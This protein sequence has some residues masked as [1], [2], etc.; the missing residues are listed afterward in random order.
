MSAAV[1]PFECIPGK[2][3]QIKIL[4]TNMWFLPVSFLAT[5]SFKNIAQFLMYKP[6]VIQRS[7]NRNPWQLAGTLHLSKFGLTI[8][9]TS[10]RT[11]GGWDGSPSPLRFSFYWGTSKQIHI[12]C[13]PLLF[14]SKWKHICWLRPIILDLPFGF[15]YFLK[16]QELTEINAKSSQKDY[17]KYKLAS[18]WFL[19]R[20]LWQKSWFWPNLHEISIQAVLRTSKCDIDSVKDRNIPHFVSLRSS[21]FLE[22]NFSCN[23]SL[24]HES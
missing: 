16:R 15:H 22:T 19:M 23:S 1:T 17:D 6:Q 13:I 3:D 4:A 24:T 2:Y 21:T 11:W 8:G 9:R 14:P 10:G 12:D 7:R 5:M 18:F 20:K